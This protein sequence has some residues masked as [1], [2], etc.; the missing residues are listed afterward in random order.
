MTKAE[1]F[2]DL[3]GFNEQ[4]LAVAFNDVDFCLRLREKNLLI[5][6]TPYAELY[7]YESLTRGSDLSPE[8]IERFKREIEYTESR[9]REMICCDPYYNPN[10][11]LDLSHGTFTLA[12]F[13]RAA[14]SGSFET[15]QLERL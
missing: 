4:D 2:K 10:L 3:N 7:H 12:P 8:N 15:Q 11:S 5:V 6:Y 14:D 13:S 9:W 1:L